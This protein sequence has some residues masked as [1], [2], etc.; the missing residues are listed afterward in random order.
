MLD[1]AL[2][3]WISSSLLFCTNNTHL[4]I[5][6]QTYKQDNDTIV[7]LHEKIQITS[8]FLKYKLIFCQVF[9][10]TAQKEITSQTD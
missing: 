9:G 2:C 10:W 4:Q 8:N 3:C 7:N 5:T 6:S 1:K